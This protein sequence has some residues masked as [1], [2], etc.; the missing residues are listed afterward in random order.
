MDGSL[1]TN[2]NFSRNRYR[3]YSL[4]IFWWILQIPFTTINGRF[5]PIDGDGDR[6]FLQVELFSHAV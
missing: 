2:P 1:S 3:K 4:C 5:V 6:F